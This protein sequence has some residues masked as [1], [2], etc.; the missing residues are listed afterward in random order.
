MTDIEKLAKQ[1]IAAR[2][3]QGLSQQSLAQKLGM[4]QSQISDLEAGKRDMRVS[5]L[6]E[7]A[8]ALGLEMVVIPRPSLP[9]V[10]Y[11]IRSSKLDGNLAVEEQKAKYEIWEEDDENQTM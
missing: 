11:L 5:T 7:V 9:A 2:K 8:R 1:L 4:K 6:I 10:S 3:E